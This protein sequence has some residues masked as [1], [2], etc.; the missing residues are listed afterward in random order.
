[1][2]FVCCQPQSDKLHSAHALALITVLVF[3]L[4]ILPRQ[5]PIIAHSCSPKI[6]VNVH[7]RFAYIQLVL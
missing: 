1:M 4:Q 2:H 7:S 5:V 3:I 6:T